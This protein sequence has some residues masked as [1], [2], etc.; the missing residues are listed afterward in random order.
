M[1]VLQYIAVK[2]ETADEAY[3]LVEDQLQNMLGG[4]P[5]GGTWYDWF[6]CGGG[7][8]NTEG[9]DD[10]KEA[11]RE[12]KTNMIIS[13]DNL[14]EFTE[15]IHELLSYRIAEYNRYRDEWNNS[16]VILD[17]YLDIYDGTTEYSMKLY[18][19]SKMIDML[20]GEWDFNSYFYDLENWSTNPKFM[21]DDIKDVGGVWYLVP[22][23]F[24]F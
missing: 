11:Y 8:F 17:E 12:G 4:E 14:A 15:K 16:G 13:S 20:Q 7:R 3:R 19:L 1:H 6:V 9:S 23:D 24:H 18:S 5:S 22:V 21:L 2:A 10:F